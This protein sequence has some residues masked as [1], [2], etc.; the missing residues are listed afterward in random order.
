MKKLLI[1][2]FAAILTFAVFL[3][4]Y[5]GAHKSVALVPNQTEEFHLLY[6]EHVGPY[7]KITSVIQSVEKIAVQ[8]NIPC[9]K[10]FGLYMNDPQQT[11]DHDR[12]QSLGG[13]LL[14]GPL[15]D[16][17][18]N[19]NYRFIGPRT[20]LKASFEGSPA[21]GPM[22]VYPKLEEWFQSARQTPG[23]PVI[24]VYEVNGSEMTTT[25]FM[26]VESQ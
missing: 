26:P 25:Y 7:H 4:F 15:E 19:V 18:E 6:K 23:K 2:F 16:Y 12:L 13:C 11:Q 10:S 22:I 24:E 14:K 9:Q 20:Y 21:I 3:Y 8:N 1:P 17:P 5:L